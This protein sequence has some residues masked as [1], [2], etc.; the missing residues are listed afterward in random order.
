MDL[1][2]FETD[3]IIYLNKNAIDITLEQFIKRLKLHLV[4]AKKNS[5]DKDDIVVEMLISLYNK[6]KDISDDE[7]AELQELL[8]SNDIP[9]NEYDDI[10]FL[11][12]VG[13]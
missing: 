3:E 12:F 13:F 11:N 1:R 10:E 2:N 4:S 7:W 8:P 5:T 6:I 9:Y